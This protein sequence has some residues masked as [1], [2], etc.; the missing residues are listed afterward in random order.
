MFDSIQ[1]VFVCV[2]VSI[3]PKELEIKIAFAAF[4]HKQN[5]RHMWDRHTEGCG[6]VVHA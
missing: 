6:R 2:C 4:A 1:K 5:A 3:Y